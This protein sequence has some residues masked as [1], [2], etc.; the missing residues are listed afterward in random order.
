MKFNRRVKRPDGRC[1]GGVLT[2]ADIIDVLK[3]LIDIRNG[4]GNVGRHRPPR[5]PPRPQRR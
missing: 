4:N 1:G 5:Q 2:R 3:V